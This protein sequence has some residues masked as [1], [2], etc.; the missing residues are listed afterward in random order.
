[1]CYRSVIHL[2]YPVDVSGDNTNA[3]G[4]EFVA[5]CFPLRSGKEE[6][7]RDLFHI[8]IVDVF[9]PTN[10][11]DEHHKIIGVTVAKTGMQEKRKM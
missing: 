2:N 4:K 1:M 5:S 8:V 3:G 11:R 10:S 9:A 6:G 7:R